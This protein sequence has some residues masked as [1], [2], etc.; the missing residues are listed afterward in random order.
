MPAAEGSVD[1]VDVG[2]AVVSG[3][4]G[5][6]RQVSKCCG[7]IALHRVCQ[8]PSCPRCPGCPPVRRR[9]PRIEGLHPGR[10][11]WRPIVQRRP[12]RQRGPRRNGTWDPRPQRRERRR[13]EPSSAG[14]QCAA[15]SPFSATQSPG[16]AAGVR[17]STSGTGSPGGRHAVSDERG[18]GAARRSSIAVAC[19]AATALAGVSARFLMALPAS[20]TIIVIGLLTTPSLGAVIACL[21]FLGPARNRYG[22]SWPMR[23]P[24]LIDHATASAAALLPGVRQHC[25]LGAQPVNKSKTAVQRVSASTSAETETE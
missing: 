22:S 18:S 23:D 20:V 14:I 5:H 3:G 7:P 4:D 17:V 9:T 10:L 8:A 25:P 11:S 13:R 1:I 19:I 2:D 12:T 6:N 21:A 15:R 24:P 16:A